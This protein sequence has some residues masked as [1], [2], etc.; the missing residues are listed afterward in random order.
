MPRG[1]P[2]RGRILSF[3]LTHMGQMVTKEELRSVSQ[4]NDKTRLTGEH[5]DHPRI[6]I[7]TIAELL[8]DT[9]VKM[10]DPPHIWGNR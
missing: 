6:Q 1:D 10:P 7:L 8:H 9:E 2:A 4:I 3:F 5:N